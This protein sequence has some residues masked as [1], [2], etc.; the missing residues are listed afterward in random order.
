MEFPQIRAMASSGPSCYRG[1][2]EARDRHKTRKRRPAG[3]EL[4]MDSEALLVCAQFVLVSP[5]AQ[6]DGGA[7]RPNLEFLV[8][9]CASLSGAYL[10][11]S[12]AI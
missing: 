7:S 2:A 10:S 3:K 11:E 5:G 12:Y 1:A 4:H 6:E 8:F 9:T